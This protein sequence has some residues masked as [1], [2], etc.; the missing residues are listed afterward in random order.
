[1]KRLFMGVVVFLLIG[2]HQP[3]LG[4]TASSL[5]DAGKKTTVAKKEEKPSGGFTFTFSLADR[6]IQISL[7][8]G[9][10]LGVSV[11]SKKPEKKDTKKSG[12]TT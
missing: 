8:G 4:Q 12:S 2:F 5:R 10:Y 1:M 9:K 6:P 7:G 3:L 11:G